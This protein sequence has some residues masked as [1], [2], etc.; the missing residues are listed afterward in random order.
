MLMV[1]A[2]AIGGSFICAL[3]LL[4]P[5]APQVIIVTA[6][7]TA[8]PPGD[9]AGDFPRGVVQRVI[10]LP[11][12]VDDSVGPGEK[13]GYRFL[14]APGLL[15]RVQVIGDASFDPLITLFNPDG[16]VKGLNDNRAAG[17]SRSELSFNAEAQGQYGLL[18]EGV[19]GTSG[20][21][22]LLLLPQEN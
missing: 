19:A 16:T 11:A 4:P 12:R 14:V 21:Y 10:S 7:A 3:W 17:E 18:I 20:G 6:P 22:T 5:R 2:L 13:H 9:I 8:T 1:L 15:W